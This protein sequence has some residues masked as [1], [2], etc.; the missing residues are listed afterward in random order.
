LCGGKHGCARTGYDL[1]RQLVNRGERPLRSQN[2]VRAF[3]YT[4]NLAKVD[5][6]EIE[7]VGPGFGVLAQFFYAVQAR[8][9]FEVC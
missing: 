7:D 5:E 8:F 2:A 1:R 6:R 3:R 9:A 4:Q